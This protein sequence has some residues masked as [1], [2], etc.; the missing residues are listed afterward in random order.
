[1]A[2]V[3]SAYRRLRLWLL[4]DKSANIGWLIFDRTTSVDWGIC[5]I[6]LR[7]ALAKELWHVT[8][9][10]GTRHYKVFCLNVEVDKDDPA[11]R[12]YSLTVLGLIVA[13][14]CVFRPKKH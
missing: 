7:V 4:G 8:L 3:K 9:A 12:L 6:F 1:M 5:V 14:G 10:T 2:V 13:F 11:L